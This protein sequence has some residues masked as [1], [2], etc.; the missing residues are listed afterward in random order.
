[1]IQALVVLFVGADLLILYVWRRL[2]KRGCGARM[3]TPDC[4]RPA[5]GPRAARSPRAIAILGIV[6][7]L[8]AFWLALPPLKVRDAARARRCR[9]PRV[10]AGVWAV[11]RGVRRLGWGAVAAGVA[12]DRARLPRHALE[13]RAPRPGRRLVG[14]AGGD[15]PLRDAADLRRDRRPVLASAA[16]S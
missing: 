6:L 16:A 11:A 13:R 10:R 3:A 9:A 4:D 2:R 8:L 5:A 14:A 7:G 1:M 15:A 12:R